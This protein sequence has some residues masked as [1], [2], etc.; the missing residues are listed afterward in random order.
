[1]FDITERR[2]AAE[3]VDVLHQALGRRAVELEKAN[4]ELE[5]FSFS[6]SHDLRA[7]LRAIDG[8]ARILCDESGGQL[9]AGGQRHLGIIR[10]NATR[11]AQLIDALLALS[12]LGRRPLNRSRVDMTALAGAVVDEV[13]GVH[14]TRDVLV[15]VHELAPAVGDA[16]LLRQLLAN[17]I[18]NAFKYTGKVA[19]PCIDVGSVVDDDGVPIY[20]VRDNGAGF[21]MR[22]AD[23]L[24]QV[25]ERL[26]APS[27]F[28]GTGIG[29]AVVRR[30]VDRHGGRVWAEGRVDD[31]ATFFFALGCEAVVESAAP[32]HSHI[33]VIGVKE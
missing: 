25:F 2:R 31:G 18:G 19:H 8:F 33:G 11:M 21:D 9:D 22:Y 27:E 15:A 32:G 30:I 6:V 26:H 10:E 5:S 3:R 14:S 28:D 29:L 12:R 7:P 20:Y 16:T 17:L 13:R 23:K 4:R 1:M 24:F